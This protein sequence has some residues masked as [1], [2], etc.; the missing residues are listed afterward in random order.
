MKLFNEISTLEIFYEE[1]IQQN[2]Q[3]EGT[4]YLMNLVIFLMLIGGHPKLLAWK[5][6]KKAN[7]IKQ[8]PQTEKREVSAERHNGKMKK[9]RVHVLSL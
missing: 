5:K 2:S 9:F 8:R 1:I 3:W 4:L 7:K 6:K